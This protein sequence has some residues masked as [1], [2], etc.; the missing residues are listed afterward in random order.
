MKTDNQL[1]AEFM[2][3][4]RSLAVYSDSKFDPTDDLAYVKYHESWDWLMPVVLK[5]KTRFGSAE[6]EGWI[7]L[8]LCLQ[9]C[10]LT[11]VYY[12]MVCFVKWYNERKDEFEK[13]L[14]EL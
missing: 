10:Q 12:E 13:Q 6:Y 1:I 11:G 9:A 5:A 14:K 4:K 2:D 3:D 8:N 7:H